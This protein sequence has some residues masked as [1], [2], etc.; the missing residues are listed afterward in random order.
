MSDVVLKTRGLC[1]NYGGR[2]AVDHVSVEISR[3]RVYGFIGKNGAGKTTFMRMVCG[4]A[5]PNVGDIEIF[6]ATGANLTSARR[7]IGSVIETPPL[8]VNMTAYE[9]METHRRTVGC[10]KSETQIKQ[11]LEWLEIADTGRKKT[12]QFSM[13]M[14][15]RLGLALTL[16]DDPDLLIL[17]EPTNGLDPTGIADMRETLKSLVREKNITILI[18]SHIL[19]ELHL[20]ATDYGIIHNGKLLKQLTADELKN[21]S[22]KYISVETDDAAKA[23]E[24][25]KRIGVTD[26]ETAADG[27]VHIN[28]A[29]AD[30]AKINSA[31][32]SAGVVVRGISEKGQEL[33]EYFL[34]LIGEGGKAAGV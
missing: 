6:G 28:D 5:A 20:L 33:E 22:K 8:Y 19:S 17:D 13:G 15:Q 34:N 3:G 29:S 7:K 23:G 32:V 9:N 1:K 4:L 16:I 2:A 14:R 21:E 25:L 10:K 24:A 27:A 30:T 12:K 31:L 18:S 26:F 11:I